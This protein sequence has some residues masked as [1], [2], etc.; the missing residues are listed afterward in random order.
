MRLLAPVLLAAAFA[1]P[2]QISRP[3]TAAPRPVPAPAPPAPFAV[4]ETLRYDARLGFVT[5][6][7][8]VAQV[9]GKA[10]VRGAATYVLSL[11]AQGGMTGFGVQ[12]DLT[13]WSGWRD[14][15]FIS[16][17]FHRRADQAGRVDEHTFE[18]LADSGLYREEGSAQA[19]AT[20]HDALDELGFLYWLRL[21][22]LSPGADLT[23][24]RY[25]RTGYNPVHVTVTGREP[26]T[27]GTGETVNCLALTV[28]AAGVSS[29]LWLTDDARRIPAQLRLQLPFGQVTLRLQA[30]PAR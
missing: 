17:R 16:R 13:S 26:V 19:W 24:S 3:A 5:V 23:L 22:P 27:L 6:G 11:T 7:T 2:A 4:G 28:S 8:A 30:L 18:I 9:T 12:Y 10:Q 25:F 1:A 29:Q 14:T 21:A 20:P 15:R